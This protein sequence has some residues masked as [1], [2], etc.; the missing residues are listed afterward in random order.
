MLA[1]GAFAAIEGGRGLGEV[2]IE[3][4]VVNRIGPQILPP[5][6]IAL[7]LV[8]LVVT[9]TYSTALSRSDSPRFFPLLL[10]FIAGVLGVEWML[11]LSGIEAV[12]MIVYVSVFAAGLL[13]LTAMWTV[14]GFTFDARQAKRL[15]PLLTSAAIVGSLAGFLTAI[16]VQRL[17]GA[18]ALILAE[19][20]LFLAAAVLLKGLGPRIR[21][22]RAP[23]TVAPTMRTAVTSG[24]TYV[25]A[26]PLM[27]LVA[28]AYVVLAIL[29]FSLTFPFM[30]AM[31]AAFPDESQLLTVLALFSAAVTI[32]SFLAGTLLTNRLYARFGVATAAMALPIMYLLGFGLWI[33]R[34]GLVT[35]LAARFAQQVT[36][37]GVSNAAFSTFYNVVPSAR[38]G[39]VLAFMD[40]V[41]GQLGT[42]LSGVL[43][44]LTS[45][46][47]MEQV[48]QMG[49][50]TSVVAIIILFL[51]RR[52]YASSLVATLREGHA[53]RLL[54]GG[55]GLAAISTDAAAVAEVRAATHSQRSSERLFAADLL[56]RLGIEAAAPDLRRL[57]S[58]SEATVR[59]AAVQALGRLG[60][61]EASDELTAALADPDAGVRAATLATL[62]GLGATDRI[63]SDTLRALE[64]D[65]DPT[66]RCEIAVTLAGRGESDL[67]RA[68]LAG[69]ASSAR[70]EERVA[71][72][73]AMSRIG[74]EADATAARAAFDDP[75]AAVRA[76]ALRASAALG[77]QA[78][79]S[80]VTALDD[81]AAL[82]RSTASAILASWPGVVPSLLQVLDDGSER[83]QHGALVALDGHADD[84]REGLLAWADDQ[85][86]RA[87]TLRGH[88]IAFSVADPM[89]T[90]AYLGEVIGRREA[91]IE[92]RLLQALAILGAPEA[93]GLIR[94][95]LH[96]PDPEVRA[97][98]IE[99][100]DALG[101]PR[102]ARGVVRLL[103]REA[104][105]DDPGEI[106]VAATALRYD[107]DPW[108]RGLALRTLS[109]H[110][111]TSTRSI[112]EQV[113]DD[114]D[115]WV[116]TAVD[117]TEG[118]H[119]MPGSPQLVSD[120]DRML[121]LRAVPIFGSLG[122]EDLQRV[123]GAAVEQSWSEG[124]VLM[125]EGE[126]G[127]EVIVIVEGSVRVVHLDADGEHVVRTYGKGDHIGELAVL[128]EAPRAATVVAGEDG[129]RGLVINGSAVHS[130]LRERPDAA[131]AMLATL[132]ERISQQA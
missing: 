105:S 62:R 8:G 83:A 15:F 110:L 91:A 1:A 125:S 10:T 98:A 20:A 27:R 88:A 2:G 96:A 107:R 26:S 13:M 35:A 61:S 114:P 23:G 79:S 77:P 29:M 75:D 19:A 51:I 56:G 9:L 87:M 94:R 24:A 123:A 72:F 14:G 63:D 16:V 74:S 113:H 100:L 34:F 45:S 17:V 78:T 43:I 121:V 99:A 18:E 95:C 11:A 44:I 47:A 80:Y 118:G 97:Q 128:R 124:D 129:V 25:A 22:R 32:V 3:T 71:A 73:D 131:M 42:M 36:Q 117:I 7:G 46:L 103:D 76:A 31:N 58:D 90:A 39:Q 41:P 12:L 57:C 109:E 48:F 60:N 33:V 21:P 85:V 115:A 119:V 30:S 102:V 54:E 69:M 108:V 40:G 81:E 64:K 111:R 59:I 92:A 53:E 50:V 84:A 126:F 65:D 38:R 6:Y 122:P 120:V 68:M 67:A 116:R 127:N 101:D 66:V 82:V 112:E 28:V 132:A 49:L 106:I 93:S 55:P 130:L 104:N 86:R 4:L 89:S 52:T 5:L 70:A 37:R